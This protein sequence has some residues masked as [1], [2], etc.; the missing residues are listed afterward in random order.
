MNE[1]LCSP[2]S[3]MEIKDAVLNIG[4][5]KALGPD[6]FQGIFFQSF[7]DIIAAKVKGIVAECLVGNGSPSSINSTNI[8][9]ILKVL[10]PETVNQFRPICLCNYSYKVMSK[11]LANQLK[12]TDKCYYFAK[13]KC[14]H[15][16]KTNSG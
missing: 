14:F 8:A 13:P 10:N 9:L 7:W 16:R 11:I 6:G 1:K 5:A 4:A 3:N 15:P 12:T 2:I